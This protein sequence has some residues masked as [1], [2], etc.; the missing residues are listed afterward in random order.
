M[1][2][3]NRKEQKER[4]RKLIV[5]TAMAEFSMKGFAATN[6]RDIAAT[7]GI[8]HGSVFA[9]FQTREDLIMAV[10]LEFGHRVSQQMGQLV[11][12]PGSMASVLSSHI[13][14]IGR[15]ELFYTRLIAEGALLPD[16]AKSE[17]A[18]I[19]TVI[20]SRLSQAYHRESENGLV[21]DLPFPMLFNSW[22]ALINHYLT[23]RDWFCPG[24]PVVETLGIQLIEFFLKTIQK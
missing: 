22:L 7:A 3:G 4:T 24:K 11:E 16:S 13:E 2:E 9:H 23:N 20:S 6:T 1:A 12:N 15:H 18:R 5:E 19:Q 17:L 8:S 21:K 10:V 14:I